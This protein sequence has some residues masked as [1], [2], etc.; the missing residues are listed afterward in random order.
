MH[1]RLRP[2]GIHE[3]LER[4]EGEALSLHGDIEQVELLRMSLIPFNKTMNLCC[5]RTAI[6]HVT[7]S[8]TYSHSMT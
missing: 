1:S 4:D 2:S 7:A 8:L 3:D 5:S 6:R